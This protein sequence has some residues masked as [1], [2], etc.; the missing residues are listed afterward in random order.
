MKRFYFS[1]KNN[2]IHY[3]GQESANFLKETSSLEEKN[4]HQEKRHFFEWWYIDITSK[5]GYH[6]VVIFHAP[7][8]TFTFLEPITELYVYGPSGKK[9]EQR[10]CIEKR[11]VILKD[12]YGVTIGNNYFK[13][14]YPHYELYLKNEDFELDL[15]FNSQTKGWKL[16]TGLLFRDNRN[17]GRYFNWVVPVPRA[18]VS[19]SLKIGNKSIEVDG[20]GYHDR[21]WGNLVLR[22]F[23]SWW[24]WGR[25][26]T[27]KYTFVYA[28]IKKKSGNITP[29]MMARKGELAISTDRV[30]ILQD[31][32]TYKNKCPGIPRQLKMKVA[33]GNEK[34]ELTTKVEKILENT[35]YYFN[36]C[37]NLFLRK[38][39][40]A[41]LDRS[42]SLSRIP[43][44]GK[45]VKNNLGRSIYLRLLINYDL[46]INSKER[47]TG[48]SIQE[49]M[50]L[51]PASK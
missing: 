46:T 44:L 28:N 2:P 17:T 25:I 45:M 42:H 43:F 10:W 4:Y 15:K 48:D 13:G 16:G 51:R 41:I 40:N 11:K 21:N 6:I 35:E 47:F 33:D 7:L 29:F 26:F 23:F 39:L 1:Q 27:D 19:G 24:Y 36:P 20:V 32:W 18:A 31:Y 38:V 8:Y 12:E 49:I 50:L 14:R 34:I 5:N 30:E 22:D 3:T 37:Q 9:I